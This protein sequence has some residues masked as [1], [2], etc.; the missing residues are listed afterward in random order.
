MI[1][2]DD[3]SK[4]DATR[5]ISW[6]SGIGGFD[7]AL[8]RAG[9]VCV[10]AC[11][12]DPFARSVYSA[13]L[14]APDFFPEDIRVVNAQE[15]PASELW[16]GGFPCTDVSNA[17][18][19]AGIDRSTRSGLIW[20]LLDLWDA[21][22]SDRA[23]E[24]L[25]LENVPG[26][27]SGRNKK[28]GRGAEERSVETPAEDDSW[29][30]IILG[31]LAD[32]GLRWAYRVLDAKYFG[33]PQRRRRV[34]ILA[35][36]SRDGIH[37]GEAL[38][39]PE[40]RSRDLE[41][42][43]A[44]RSKVARYAV[45][46]AGVVGAP[47]TRDGG[48]D[49]NEAQAGQLIVSSGYGKWHEDEATGTLQSEGK[50]PRNLV[51]SADVAPPVRGRAPGAHTNGEAASE[52]LIG[53]PIPF[54]LAQPTSRENRSACHLGD[55]N[56]SL[57][58]T[59]LPM[60]AFSLQRNGSDVQAKVGGEPLGAIRDGHGMG[61]SVLF[62]DSWSM[63]ASGSPNQSPVKTD[64]LSDALN[65]TS[66]GG[67]AIDS[68]SSMAIRRLTPL[69]CER[70]MGFPNGWTAIPGASD[71]A[72]YKACGNAVVVNVVEWIAKR[73]SAVEVKT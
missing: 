50:R 13:R 10:G 55:P 72:R 38:L 66:P 37:P 54:D 8:T 42:R 67:V 18:R 51:A 45:A 7:L 33:V 29:M 47:G 14:G 60:V 73:L 5:F 19:R 59:S 1:L 39:E 26:L 30:G 31:A 11:E 32:R 15:I 71:T 53:L 46:G 43:G 49:D 17:G 41:A 40:S 34:F 6:F 23:P 3:R 44:K 68:P 52:Y 58:S 62:L 22:P 4:I 61:A 16:C 70:L 57:T 56:G 35:R 36:R 65:L 48:A 25:L 28:P 24:W 21:V 12:I 27:L 63:H 64:G 20:S 2:T 9:Y 69:E